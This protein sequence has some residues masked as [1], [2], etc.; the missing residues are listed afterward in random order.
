MRERHTLIWVPSEMER[1]TDAL[2]VPDSLRPGLILMRRC[3]SL[4]DERC[5]VRR[6]VEWRVL[7]RFFFLRRGL[8]EDLCFRLCLRRV[9]RVRPSLSEDE[10]LVSV[11]SHDEA[12]SDWLSLS[13][14]DLR[15][16]A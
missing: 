12:E 10:E 6:R 2:G 9:R 11:S 16:I 7:R 8:P 4:P 14:G 5:F 13:L 15:G 1:E 3:F